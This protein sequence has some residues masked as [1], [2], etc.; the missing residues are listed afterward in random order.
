MY[1]CNSAG[2]DVVNWM[3]Y[4]SCLNALQQRGPEDMHLWDVNTANTESTTKR[5][6]LSQRTPPTSSN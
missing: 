4:G 3:G 6:H 5:L 1:E 2:A